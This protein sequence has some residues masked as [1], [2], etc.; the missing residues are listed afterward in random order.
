MLLSWASPRTYIV[1]FLALLILQDLLV[2]YYE[3]YRFTATDLCTISDQRHAGGRFAHEHCTY[4]EGIVYEWYSLR[5]LLYLFMEANYKW[6]AAGILCLGC[7]NTM[8]SA[9]HTTPTKQV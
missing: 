7:T 3:H 1:L 5:N 6:I 2:V 8:L 4:H 9:S